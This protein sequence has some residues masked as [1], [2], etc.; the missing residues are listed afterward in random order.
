MLD[1][2]NDMDKEKIHQHKKDE[3]RRVRI[4]C[5]FKLDN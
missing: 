5:K 2:K 4:G 1:G 3:E